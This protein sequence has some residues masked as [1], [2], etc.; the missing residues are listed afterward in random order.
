MVSI[1]PHPSKGFQRPLLLFTKF[2]PPSETPESSTISE[3][4]AAADEIPRNRA[5]ITE[6]S[7]LARREYERELFP[8]ERHAEGN[9]SE[10]S[11]RS[12]GSFSQYD[13]L[14]N[15]YAPSATPCYETYNTDSQLE[16]ERMCY[17]DVAAEQDD[18]G[19]T[20]RQSNEDSRT[21]STPDNT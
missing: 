20:S 17:V 15:V 9:L 13:Q 4:A 14:E 19:T 18:K 6:E 5:E 1:P 3:E 11:I 8:S 12:G 16:P 7:E 2:A 10:I 21:G